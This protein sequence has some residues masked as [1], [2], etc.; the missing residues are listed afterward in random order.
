MMS[1]RRN[2]RHLALRRPLALKPLSIRW[3]RIFDRTLRAQLHPERYRN[4]T[5]ECRRLNAAYPEGVPIELIEATIGRA[6]GELG[7]GCVQR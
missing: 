3:W 2:R 1:R 6:L 7:D 5:E 4:F